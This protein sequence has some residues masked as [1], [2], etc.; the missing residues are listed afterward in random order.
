MLNPSSVSDDEEADEAE[1]HGISNSSSI[2]K[3][4][5]KQK[6]EEYEYEEQVATVTVVED[7]DPDELIYGPQSRGRSSPHPDGNG[8]STAMPKMRSQA[9]EPPQSARV[10]TSAKSASGP[11]AAERA[12]LKSKPKPKDIKYQTN[13]ARKADKLKQRKRKV[14]KAERAGGKAS[15]KSVGG[16]KRR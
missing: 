14:E 5:G 13:A 12:K 7:F 2:D 15:R 11:A 6:E 3:G 9:R 4:K 16:R 8:L 1:W 10:I